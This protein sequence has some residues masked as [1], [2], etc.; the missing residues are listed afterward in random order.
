MLAVLTIAPLATT[1]TW[2]RLCTAVRGWLSNNI[3]KA[4]PTNQIECETNLSKSKPRKSFQL[5]NQHVFFSIQALRHLSWFRFHCGCINDGSDG[6]EGDEGDE[7]DDDDD[8]DGDDDDDEEDEDEDEDDNGDEKEEEY[9]DDDD[10]GDDGDDAGK[11]LGAQKLKYFTEP[12]PP[13]QKG[14]LSFLSLRISSNSAALYWGSGRKTESKCFGKRGERG[15]SVTYYS[16][17]LMHC[18]QQIFS[19]PLSQRKEK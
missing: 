11:P 9:D 8:D 16:L 14:C 7:G 19:R 4:N 6:D 10:D 18:F 17:S 15:P 1:T 3:G 5:F 13:S 2:I 12:D